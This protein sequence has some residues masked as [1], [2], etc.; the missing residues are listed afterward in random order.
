MGAD[1]SWYID[2]LA[3]MAD[4][5]EF[6]LNCE[7]ADGTPQAE[8]QSSVVLTVAMGDEGDESTMEEGDDDS[9]MG[10]E[11]HQYPVTGTG[12]LIDSRGVSAG[13]IGLLIAI[14]VVAVTGLGLRRVRNR[15]YPQARLRNITLTREV[16]PCASTPSLCL[17]SETV[18]KVLAAEVSEKPR[19]PSWGSCH[20]VFSGW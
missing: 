5:V 9:M 11:E 3:A 13:L 15:S 6:T 16:G 17:T 12:S 7:H 1:G 20:R 8:D 4:E 18:S 19:G 14:G 2:V 10:D